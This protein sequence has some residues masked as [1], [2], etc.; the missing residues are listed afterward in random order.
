MGD[1]L[2]P[3]GAAI[4][5]CGILLVARAGFYKENSRAHFSLGVVLLLVGLSLLAAGAR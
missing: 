4:G 5:F 3:I 2:L 1:W